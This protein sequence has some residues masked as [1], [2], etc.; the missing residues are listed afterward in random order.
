PQ[1]L[2]L[3]E[4]EVA[5]DLVQTTERVRKPAKFCGVLSGFAGRAFSD[6]RDVGRQNCL[7]RVRLHGCCSWFFGLKVEGM[8][9]GTLGMSCH[10]DGAGV[11]VVSGCGMKGIVGLKPG[12][13]GYSYLRATIGSS[14]VARR[15]GITVAIPAT[16]SKRATVSPNGMICTCPAP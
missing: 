4:A 9:E 6:G 12:V 14:V 5:G 11:P 10:R 3:R 15:T 1:L 8:G 7:L 2:P 16:L 13:A